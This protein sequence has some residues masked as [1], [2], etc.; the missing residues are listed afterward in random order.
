[1]DDLPHHRQPYGFD[2]LDFDFDQHG[3][4]FDGKCLAII[5]LPEYGISGIRTGQYEG[6]RRFW[7]EEISV[8]CWDRR[9]KRSEGKV[10]PD[11]RRKQ[12][13]HGR[14]AKRP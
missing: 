5:P 11:M 3:E 8:P 13:P 9:D 1:M 7:T 12:T 14:L 2:N 10:P 4:R 6:Y